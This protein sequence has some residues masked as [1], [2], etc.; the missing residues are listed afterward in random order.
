M[1]RSG[2]GIGARVSGVKGGGG[3]VERSGDSGSGAGG[4]ERLYNG[5]SDVVVRVD[6][7]G[8]VGGAGA[9]KGDTIGATVSKARGFDLAWGSGRFDA[10][11]LNGLSSF[12]SGEMGS[13][14]FAA[15]NFE[16]GEGVFCGVRV[17]F[18]IVG[19]G[20]AGL[21]ACLRPVS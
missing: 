17:S 13:C 9:S 8:C 5:G 3:V 2:S 16:M 15:S 12:L 6:N 10:S 18:F 7:P 11:K 21:W 4:V 1:R 14:C 19:I 20:G